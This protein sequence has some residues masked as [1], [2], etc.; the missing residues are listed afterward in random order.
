MS[1]CSNKKHKGRFL[2]VKVKILLFYFAFYQNLC[3][4]VQW[5]CT[6]QVPYQIEE[7]DFKISILS[8]NGIILEFNIQNIFGMI[9]Y[10]KIYV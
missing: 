2:V 10:P 6:V 7:V 1:N 4:K 3:R 9:I 8:N 5:E